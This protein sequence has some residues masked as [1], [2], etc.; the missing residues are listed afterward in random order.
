[1]VDLD[2][3]EGVFVNEVFGCGVDALGE[4]KGGGGRG[5]RKASGLGF[6]IR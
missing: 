6:C 3:A 4:C 1:V 2:Q 5:G